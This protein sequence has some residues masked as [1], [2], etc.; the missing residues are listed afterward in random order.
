M[1]LLALTGFALTRNFGAVHAAQ[2]S[3]ARN[4][5][6]LSPNETTMND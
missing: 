5:Q 3:E 6:T 4:A 2:Q 1:G